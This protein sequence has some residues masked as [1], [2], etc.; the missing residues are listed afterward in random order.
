MTDRPDL[1]DPDS[2]PESVRWCCSGNAEDC[3]LCDTAALPYPWICPGHPDTAENRHRSQ[4]AAAEPEL[5]VEEARALVDD[6]GLQLYRAQ[7]A[8]AFVGECCD[9]ADREQTADVREWLKGA[10]CGRQL[11]ADSR[12]P[13]DAGPTVAEAAAQDRAYWERKDAGDRP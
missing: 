1:E 8:L 5:T 10:R 2:I 9:I 13:H 12:G 4:M 11:A 6:L 7:D 3:P